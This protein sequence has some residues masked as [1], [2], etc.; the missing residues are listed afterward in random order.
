MS[1]RRPLILIA[2]ALALLVTL[3]ASAA[4]RR[5]AARS[6]P[7]AATGACHT[8]GLVSAGRQASYVTQAPSGNVTFTITWLTDTPTF[9]H[10]TQ[11]VTTPQG[12]SDVDTTLNGEVFGALRGLK[13]LKVAGSQSVPGFGTI[14]STT[15]IDF[16]PTLT[17]GPAGGWCVNSTW[18]VPAVTETIVSSTPV[19]QNTQIVT[20]VASEGTV[21]AVG[22]TVSVPA[23]NFQTVKY[24]GAIVSGTSVQTAITWVSMEHNIVVKQDTIDGS[25]AVT[26]T[27]QL[28]AVH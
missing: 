9:T 16:V 22:E 3:P 15:D 12:T 2:L 25:G 23:G 18:S 4:V 11:K 21:L 28:T 1:A 17:Q 10:T 20:T 27:T 14:T 8:F 5:R 7:A 24:R 19:G 26:S 13:H 6:G